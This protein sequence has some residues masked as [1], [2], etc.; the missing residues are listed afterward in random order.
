[1]D[2][3]AGSLE[4]RARSRCR[5]RA[6]LARQGRKGLVEPCDVVAQADLVER[7]A[8]AFPEPVLEFVGLT[9]D[10]PVLRA[11]KGFTFEDA[12]QEYPQAP[13]G[14]RIAEEEVT[15]VGQLREHLS[16]N[17]LFDRA[18]AHVVDV[19]ILGDHVV[20]RPRKATV[21]VIYRAVQMH[22][23]RA[24]EFAAVSPGHD[25][26]AVVFVA[27]PDGDRAAA[28][29]VLH[30]GRIDVSVVPGNVHETTAMLCLRTHE[31]RNV[32]LHVEGSERALER[33]VV[34][35]CDDHRVMRFVSRALEALRQFGEKR[36]DGARI[37]IDGENRPDPSEHPRV[38]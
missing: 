2:W 4:A 30:V 19:V 35:W 29:P 20:F 12:L 26:E 7:D 13:I 23:H 21:L 32:E 27:Y 37:G 8:E 16:G 5:R 22:D 36:M 33:E 1:M 31:Q 24:L 10:R 28:I 38:A 6:W 25:W 14:D 9:L 34:L 18:I 15:G 17:D 3:F 11:A